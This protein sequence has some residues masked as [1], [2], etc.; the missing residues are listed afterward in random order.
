MTPTRSRPH[1]RPLSHSQ[2]AALTLTTTR[3]RSWIPPELAVIRIRCRPPWHSPLG[4]TR[5]R[6]CC[7]ALATAPYPL[8]PPATT[9][10]TYLDCRRNHPHS[11]IHAQLPTCG[12]RLLDTLAAPSVPTRSRPNPSTLQNIRTH[13]RLPLHPNIQLLA[14]SR[15]SWAL[16]LHAPPPTTVV[17]GSPELGAYLCEFEQHHDVATDTGAAA[18]DPNAPVK[19]KQPVGR[20]AKARASVRDCIDPDLQ[21]ALTPSNRQPT[22]P[23]DQLGGAVRQ[24]GLHESWRQP[25]TEPSS[26]PPIPTATAS[27]PTATMPVPSL[28]RE[29]FIIPEEDPNRSIGGAEDDEDTLSGILGEGEGDEDD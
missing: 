19:E 3:H 24:Q 18:I 21:I 7:H 16:F 29:H 15:A 10:H 23:V 2:P 9:A 22:A 17:P 20:P 14:S 28:H 5:A 12:R 4:L 8:H 11:V 13:M 6:R 25:T 27:S 26:T 1:P